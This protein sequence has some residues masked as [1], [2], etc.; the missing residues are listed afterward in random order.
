MKKALFTSGT[1]LVMALMLL[2]STS[3]NAQAIALQ[4][5]EPADNPNISGNSPWDRACGSSTFNE[6]YVTIKW[7]GSANSDNQFILELSNA[8][9]SFSS[10]TV[11]ST[12]TDQNNN[13]EFLTSFVL[14]TDIQGAGYRMRVRSTSPAT[15]SPASNPYSMYYLG[16]TNNLHMSPNGDGST[17]GTLEVCGGGNVTL[18]VDNVPP[19][20]LN[21]YQYSWFRS[22]T[23]IGNGPSIETSGD[24]EYFVY[25]DYGDCTGSA[26]TESNHII[27][28]SGTSSGIAINTPASTSLCAGE[29]AP[30]LETNVQNGSYS[31]IWYKDGEIVQAEQSG[32]FTYTIDTDNPSFIGDYTVQIKGSGIC[33]ETSQSVTI[34]N[35]GAFTVN[36]SNSENMVILP[37][38]TQTLSVTTDA[39]SPT[40]QWY[41]NGTA[42]P[43]S[44]SS[45]LEISQAG[46]YYAAVTQTGGTCSSTTINSE[47]T[48]A[49]SPTEFRLE[50]D[51][52][53]PYSECSESSI[54]LETANVY[55][56]LADS[57]EINVTD[58]IA[59]S[60]SYQWH[61]DGTAVNGE[62]A[63]SI[64]LTSSD[65][66]GSYSV[67]GAFASMTSTSNVLPVQLSSNASLTITSSST[68]YCSAED[69]ITIE[70]SI[71]LTDE[72]F[73]WEKDGNV[74][75]STDLSLNV[76]EPGTYRLV[77][78]KGLCPL[79]SN[80]IVVA[81]L[82][83]D[84]ITFDVDGDVIFPEG[85]SKTVTAS[86]GSSYRWFDANNVEIG[87]TSSITFTT[88]GNY[89]LVANVDNCE[90][91]KPLTVAYLDLFNI[92]N[93]ITPNGDGAN[94]QWIIPNSYSNK[95]DVN[96]IIYNAQGAE[97]LNSTNYSNNWPESSM[98]FSNQNMVFYYVIKN[99]AETLKQGT[100]TVI[101]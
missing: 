5:P 45:S 38:Q 6:Y 86:G 51:Y 28:N 56:V 78:K 22:G 37:S 87:S 73:E 66:N 25:I 85:S 77:V 23:P 46:T 72:D 93:V 69:T 27:I 32:A 4:A 52:A 55:A 88:E 68:V 58:D 26:N 10:P 84:L 101:R 65:E 60:F 39:N 21:T 20:D 34:T 19:S 33:T 7:A 31:Y 29:S 94:D 42:I 9:G 53:T 49:V 79:I 64:S 24:G 57:S 62:S 96:V 99:A 35:A 2:S 43:S 15:T 61:K 95:S 44:N 91:A 83:P 74:I 81:P 70:A 40:Y 50:I 89:T 8:S 18:S 71:D 3:I 100:I 13:S 75:S 30:A 97:V 59:T 98:A 11:I 16:F 48:I 63:R 14:G 17:P 36:R 1:T 76:S 12:I 41:R 67:E 92:P 54:V 47:N 80:E 90:V 82:N